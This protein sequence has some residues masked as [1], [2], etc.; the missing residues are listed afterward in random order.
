MNPDI[1]L[2]PYPGI[3]LSH[4]H[5]VQ[6][7]PD[8]ERALVALQVADVLG[9][10]TESKPVF[11]KG[12]QSTG[13]HLI[14]L[15]TDTQVFLF[16]VVAA[17]HTTVVVKAVLESP[18][19]LKVGFGLSDDHKRLHAKLDILP[20]HVL[21]LSRALRGAERG[22][23]GAK[24]AVAQYFGMRLQKSKKVSTSNWA[25]S[26]LNERQIKYA[27]DDAQVALL[28]YRKWL[29]LQG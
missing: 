26:P 4:V 29:A 6:S 23:V 5:L 20:K 3:S 10:D 19:I 2:P 15:A 8:A 28:V 1:I 13:P 9:F 24:S 14:Q 12:Q 25:A 21:D 22:D 17:G 11:F 16:P 27:A 18:Q 7:L